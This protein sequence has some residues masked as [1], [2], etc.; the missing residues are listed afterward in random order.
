VCDLFIKAN[1]LEEVTTYDLAGVFNK[2]YSQVGTIAKE[3]SGLKATEIYSLGSSVIPG[4]DL[5]AVGMS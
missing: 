3:V 5:L 4:E 2:A 1:G